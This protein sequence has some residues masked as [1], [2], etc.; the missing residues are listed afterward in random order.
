MPS[1]RQ[2]KIKTLETRLDHLIADYQAASRQISLQLDEVSR[3][4]LQRQIE[5]L[6][7]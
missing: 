2:V 5:N 7:Q 3:Q 6:E 1:F 4:R